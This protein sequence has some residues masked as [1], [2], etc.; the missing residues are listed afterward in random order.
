MTA[1]EDEA[2]RSE[3]LSDAS[4]E[5]VAGGQPLH[6]PIRPTWPRPIVITPPIIQ[7]IDDPIA[8]PIVVDDR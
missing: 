3:E 1:R 4:L 7:P 8:L 5:Q 6:T 2:P